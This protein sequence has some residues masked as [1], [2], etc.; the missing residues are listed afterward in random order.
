MMIFV[1]NSFGASELV[2]GFFMAQCYKLA[3]KRAGLQKPAYKQHGA[4]LARGSRLN[5]YR[6]P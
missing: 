5:W 1:F 4:T 2:A 3:D 6:C